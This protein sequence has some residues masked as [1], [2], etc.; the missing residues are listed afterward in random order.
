MKV[1]TFR[2]P[3]VSF[4]SWFV[5]RSVGMLYLQEPGVGFLVFV[6]KVLFVHRTETEQAGR[7]AGKQRRRSRL[8]LSGE[9]AVGLDSGTLR[10]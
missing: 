8:P 5:F 7:V 1:C 4:T 6:F 9:P 3:R 2:C 10:P